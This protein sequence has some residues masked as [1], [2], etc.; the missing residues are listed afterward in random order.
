MYS[1]VTSGRAIL[2]A[3]PCFQYES[4]SCSTFSVVCIQSTHVKVERLPCCK[5]TLKLIVSQFLQARIRT[6]K[7]LHILAYSTS[8][9]RCVSSQPTHTNKI[10]IVSAQQSTFVSLLNPCRPS[11]MNRPF[12][13]QTASFQCQE[14]HREQLLSVSHTMGTKGHQIKLPGGK[15]KTKKYTS[16]IY[17]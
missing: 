5:L 11:H 2:R 15:F 3:C 10:H 6:L 14:G 12:L 8:K 4:T 13:E 7:P 16:Y 9:V 1:T 17:Y